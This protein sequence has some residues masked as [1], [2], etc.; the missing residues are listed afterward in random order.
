MTNV[1][2]LRRKP[3]PLR[4]T[5]NPISPYEVEREDQDDGSIWFVVTD[6]RPDTYRTVCQTNDYEGQNRYAKTDAENVARGLNLLVQH[7][8]EVL[9]KRQPNKPD[10]FDFDDEDDQS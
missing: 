10:D 1:I 5:Y 3:R 4:A 6:M 8:L 9:P 7:N 2:Q